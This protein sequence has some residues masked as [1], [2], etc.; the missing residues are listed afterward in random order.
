[1]LRLNLNQGFRRSLV[2][3]VLSFLLVSTHAQ[4]SVARKWCEVLLTGIRGDFARPTVHARNLHHVSAAMYDAWAAYEEQAE[5]FMLG[6]NMNGFLMPFQGVEVSV[7]KVEAQKEAISYAAYTLIRFRFSASPGR[8]RTLA[9]GDSLMTALGYDPNYISQDYESNIPAALGN[10]IAQSYLKYGVEDNSNEFRGYRNQFYQPINEFLQPQFPGNP[11][12]T[13]PNRWQGLSLTTFIDQSG[14]PVPGRTVEF[15]SPEWGNVP[16][17][18]LKEE[19][20]KTFQRDGFDWN[21]YLDPGA[22]CLMDTL[23]GATQ[24]T[25]YQW[26]FSLVSLWSSHLDPADSV[27]WDISPGASGNNNIDDF[28][29]DIVGLRNFYNTLEGGDP[30]LGREINPYTGQPYEPNIVPRG[31][32]TRVLAE[33]WADGPDSETPPGHWFSIL[34]YVNDHPAS[35]RKFMGEGE[36]LSELEW[37]IKAYFTLGG[38]MHDAAIA[39]WSVKGYYD[40]IRPISAI[41]Y[42]ADQGQSSDPNLPNYDLKGLP[43]YPGLI[44][45]VGAE[46]PLAI[47]SPQHVNKIKVYAW[48]GPDYIDDPDTTAAGVGWILAE[49]WWPYQRPSF[50]TPPFAGYVSGHSTFS[51]AAAEILTQFTGDEYFPGGVGEFVAKQNEFLVFEEGPSQDIVLQWATYRDASDETSL[52]RIW[53]GIHPPV[54]DIP[55]RIMGE[56]VGESAFELA[57]SYFDGSVEDTPAASDAFVSPNPF[58]IGQ[59][60]RIRYGL[61]AEIVR[62][63]VISLDGRH[64]LN[65]FEELANQLFVDLE[66]TFTNLTS[67]FYLVRLSSDDWSTTA[68]VYAYE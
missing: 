63:E 60:V 29:T 47:D 10:Y 9:L 43:L 54:D 40:Y 21:V 61:G 48:R 14:N 8:T 57:A 68:K 6:K 26:G 35:T 31:D 38:A 17:F 50:V 58:Q 30:G 5:T 13:D 65:T 32:Y 18:S 53:G 39:A 59:P 55:G 20:K 1:M 33:F 23:D 2:L 67:G 34:N 12:I 11:A 22:P 25:E 36:D 44:E 27:M 37:D 24:S 49:N 46:D 51:R 64:V 42:M 15:L 19:D 3:F 56:K 7:D 41:R 62:V 28:P 66:F 45:L 52:S 16:P 4:H